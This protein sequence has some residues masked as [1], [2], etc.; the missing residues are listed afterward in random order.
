MW[1][2]EDARDDQLGA[3]LTSDPDWTAKLDLT[4]GGEADW[5]PTADLSSSRPTGERATGPDW[6]R[7]RKARKPEAVMAAAEEE[8]E[9][10]QPAREQPR[11]NRVAAGLPCR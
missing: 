6:A 7:V 5:Q 9:E 4:G 3:S 2:S 11:R 8:E 10:E 1:L